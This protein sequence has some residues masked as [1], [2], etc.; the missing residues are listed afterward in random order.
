[1]EY[2][3]ENRFIYEKY[4]TGGVKIIHDFYRLTSLIQ[5]F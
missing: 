5:E 3:G 1:M 2:T 4:T